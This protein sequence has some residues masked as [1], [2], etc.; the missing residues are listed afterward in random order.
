M[1]RMPTHFICKRCSKRHKVVTLIEYPLPE[2]ISNISSGRVQGELLTISKSMYRV[3]NELFALSSLVIRVNDYDDDLEIQNWVRIK[4]SERESVV[5]QYNKA[6]EENDIDDFEFVV[7]GVMVYP[8]PHYGMSNYPSV[9]V[10]FRGD[11]FTV[12]VELAHS[13]S[14]LYNDWKN[15]ISIEYLEEILTHLYHLE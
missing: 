14:K 11:D 3:D 8:V 13:T 5:L 12:R 2:N 7:D 9:R 15:G 6:K 10:V 4:N 1:K